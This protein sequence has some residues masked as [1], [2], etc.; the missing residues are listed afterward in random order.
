MAEKI[1]DIRGLSAPECEKRL[2]DLR[3]SLMKSYAQVAQGSTPKNPGQ[4]KAMKKTIARLLTALAEKSRSQSVP[5]VKPAGKQ[6]AKK[7]TKEDAKKD[8]R[9]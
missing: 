1:R 6:T 7:S 9:N 5:S 8:G 2:A 3:L 4:I